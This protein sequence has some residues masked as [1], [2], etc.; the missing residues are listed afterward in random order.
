MGTTAIRQHPEAFPGS[1]PALMHR[2]SAL[3]NLH[4]LE[5]WRSMASQI[6]IY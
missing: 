1:S 2:L 6:K 5:P 4:S 3:I